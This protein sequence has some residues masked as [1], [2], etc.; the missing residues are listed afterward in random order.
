MSR[1]SQHALYSLLGLLGLLVTV[2][3]YAL[4]LSG[5]FVFDDYPN[6]VKNPAL[7]FDP[8]QL[9]GWWYAAINGYPG[10]I[11]R[12][13]SML[14]LAINIQLGATNPLG[15]KLVNFGI[16]LLTGLSLGVL[17][18]LLLSALPRLSLSHHERL[19]IAI[20][21]ATAWLVHPLN[22]TSV[23]YVVQRMNSL[24]VLFLVWGTI[25]YVHG[26]LNQQ[27]GTPS[28]RWILTGLFG[29]GALAT[30]SKEI[31][32]LLPL[33]L[34]VVETCVFRFKS[35]DQ[36]TGL[37]LIGLFV[38]TLGLPLLGLIILLAVSPDSLLGA[39][40]VR[41]FSLTERLLTEPRV[42]LWYLRMLVVPV[43]SEMGL[44]LDDLPISRSLFD[45]ASTLPAMLAVLG[46]LVTAVLLRTKAPVPA[47]AGLWFLAGHSME[48]T[49]FPLEIA[50]EHRNYL[51]GF[52]VLLAISYTLLRLEW[53]SKKA[54][55]LRHAT[56]IAWIGLLAFQLGMRAHGWGNELRH[57]HMELEHHPESPRNN[58]EVGA[59]YAVLARADP[60]TYVDKAI[61]RFEKAAAIAPHSA[62]ALTGNLIVRVENG[63]DVPPALVARLQRVLA[64]SPF[65]ASNLTAVNGL[66]KCQLTGVDCPIPKKI[67]LSLLDAVLEN[68]TLDRY[69]RAAVYINAA[70]YHGLQLG[71]HA[72]AVEYARLAV[73]STPQDLRY[74][75]YY[76]TWLM[77]VNNLDAAE[78]ELALAKELDLLFTMNHHLTTMEAKLRQ[79][80]AAQKS[81]K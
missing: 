13:L 77:A 70:D 73:E 37:R 40:N 7:N 30:L 14:S 74:R 80:R 31:G 18:Y 41:D 48:S 68:P 10:L 78:R 65:D 12:P 6:I 29:F 66:T 15:F 39:Y 26:R 59:L 3:C 63:R 23:L 79:L 55:R 19:L 21:A 17:G 54:L 4:G 22:L 20:V 27:T 5:G 24:A 60:E 9:S 34:L 75:I 1:L 2:A 72:R 36:K 47:F 76:A 71:D 35:P 45:P 44:Y 25:F 11:G 58:I 32:L 38:L 16:H 42:L 81:K 64:E 43:I 56:V 61:E 50:F 46:L 51:P 49:I 69:S 57:Y 53:G 33:Y 28:W 8:S 52:G 67:F 62:G